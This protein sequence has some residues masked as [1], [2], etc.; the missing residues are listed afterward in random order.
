MYF[1]YSDFSTYASAN[2]RLN[3][4][5]SKGGASTSWVW[6]LHSTSNDLSSGAP[7]STSARSI[8]SSGLAHLSIVL[9]W[10]SLLDLSGGY[11]SNYS[12][13]L[14]D[15]RSIVPSSHLVWS[16]LGQDI[17]NSYLGGSYEGLPILSGLFY[18]WR[19]IGVSSPAY[20]KYCSVALSTLS[21]FFVF[22]AY[23]FQ[24]VLFVR[25]YSFS[26][27]SSTYL[28]LSNLLII[29]GLSSI[30]WSGHLFHVS[31]PFL[32]S[33]DL[34]LNPYMS[35]SPSYY[36]CST[37]FS[38]SSIHPEVASPIY[39]HLFLGI[40]IIVLGI[41]LKNY[42]YSF[43]S[44]LSLGSNLVLSLSLLLL[45]LS[46]ILYSVCV[47]SFCVWPLLS[48]DYSTVTC[49]TFHHLYIGSIFILGSSS[50]LSIYFIRE[51][52]LNSID[53]NLIL[54]HRCSILGHLS[55]V[56]LF[57]GLH[58]FGIYI[59]N[60]T[61]CS[62]GRFKDMFS[63]MTIPLKPLFKNWVS[64]SFF[65]YPSLV[66]GKLSSSSI[67]E[68][69]SDFILAH[70][71]SFTLHVTILI[72]LKGILYS[73]SSR[74]VSDKIYLGWVYPCDGPGRGG[75]CQ[76]SSFDHVFLSFFWCY[77]CISV[78]TFG[79]FWKLQS[80]LWG[81][82]DTTTL[83]LNHLSPGDYGSSSSYVNGWLGTFLWSQSSQVIQTYG[84][85]FS[86]YGLVFLLSHFVWALSLMF[87]FSGRGYWEELIESI[88][89]SHNKVGVLVSLQ[90]RAL[91]IAQGR[92]V[93]LLHYLLGGVD[94]KSV[95]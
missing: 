31:S 48:T 23:I 57:L 40:S 32:K 62:L 50:H 11:C 69:T 6:D 54:A 64:S 74:L 61:M 73:R 81:Y 92:L 85:P 28:S 90:P 42:N 43:A 44:I 84:S 37:E 14:L 3:N 36:L 56:C 58:S 83:T 66:N 89:W 30:S 71:N 13:W 77:N 27:R 19:S 76:V 9:I 75:S 82:Y 46:S 55:Y 26:S 67:P 25:S 38:L 4:V 59:H 49:I 93:G 29:S 63:D 17:L 10:L 16:L 22:L 21:L 68:G 35:P 34:G 2:V 5:A 33:I 18:L 94:R 52:D 8:F 80:D 72:L 86:C 15:P 24:H 1:I 87:L 12:S 20:L 79:L 39:H 47:S 78:L 45:G 70:I 51:L 95:V 41:L 65:V 60:D 7:A 53:F 91:S 88:C